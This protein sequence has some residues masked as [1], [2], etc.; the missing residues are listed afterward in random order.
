[1]FFSLVENVFLLLR[2]I[3][4]TCKNMFPL[5][6]NIF[7]LLGKLVLK[8][9]KM[10]FHQCQQVICFDY[11]KKCV[12]TSKN[13]CFMCFHQQETFFHFYK[14]SFLQVTICISTSGRNVSAAGE[15]SFT[16]KMCSHQ[17]KIRSHLWEIYFLQVKQCVSTSGKIFLRLGFFLKFFQIRVYV[18][19]SGKHA[20]NSGNSQFLQEKISVSTSGNYVFSSKKNTFYW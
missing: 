4:L 20:S 2:K 1:M 14:N 19:A 6:G 7:L 16:G 9:K 5:L 3:V 12:F 18:S 13:M 10:C 8:F 15:N 17:W 11:C